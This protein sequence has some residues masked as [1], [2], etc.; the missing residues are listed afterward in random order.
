MRLSDKL[1]AALPASPLHGIGPHDDQDWAAI[2]AWTDGLPTALRLEV[3]VSHAA[4]VSR[5][6]AGCAGLLVCC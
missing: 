1:I 2:D 6:V 3:P 4:T 5:P